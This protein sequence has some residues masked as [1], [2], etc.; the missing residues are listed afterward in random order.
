MKK[1]DLLN[2][3]C[4][5][6]NFQALAEEK[7]DNTG[8]KLVKYFASSE[9]LVIYRINFGTNHNTENQIELPITSLNWIKDTIK[10]GFWRLPS[11]GGLSKN[12]HS[13]SKIF[14]QEEIIVGRSMNAG[15]Y[16]K[17]GFK[18]VNKGRSSHI[19]SSRP[20]EYQITDERVET[21]LLPAIEELS[22]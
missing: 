3:D 17:P 7:L 21:V 2:C 18:I 4:Q 22:V 10:N 12:Q 5:T 9:L 11:E 19:M 20:Q 16:G 15:D 14:N 8:S 13:V 1:V 6:S